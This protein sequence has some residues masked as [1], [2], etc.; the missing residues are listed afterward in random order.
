MTWTH[1]LLEFRVLHIA[2]LIP[3]LSPPPVLQHNYR[4][5][6]GDLVTCMNSGRHRIDTQGAVPDMGSQSLLL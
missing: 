2:N 1:Q 5:G 6:L 4:G 3:S